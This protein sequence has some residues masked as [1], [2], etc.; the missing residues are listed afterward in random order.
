[1]WGYVCVGGSDLLCCFIVPGCSGY[2]FHVP[3]INVMNIL[4][5]SLIYYTEARSMQSVPWFDFA[6]ITD[7]DV[8][9]WGKFICNESQNLSCNRIKRLRTGSPIGFN[10]IVI[11]WESTSRIQISIMDWTFHSFGIRWKSIISTHIPRNMYR[12][13]QLTFGPL[14]TE[15]VKARHA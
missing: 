5:V 12:I 6:K 2:K 1:M 7:L 8:N 3:H 14:E 4:V 9:H 11:C 15:A 13:A 10:Q